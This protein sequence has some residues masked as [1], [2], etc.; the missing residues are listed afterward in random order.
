MLIVAATDDILAVHNLVSDHVD[1][2]LSL[3]MQLS[4]YL[5][6]H[7]LSFHLLVKVKSFGASEA[8]SCLLPWAEVVKTLVA[9]VSWADGRLVSIAILVHVVAW[10]VDEVGA[11]KDSAF[12]QLVVNTFI[13]IFICILIW[14]SIFVSTAYK[15]FMSAKE[16]ILAYGNFSLHLELSFGVCCSGGL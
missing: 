13:L 10:L 15:T 12:W 1:G 8:A 5:L 3:I 6:R 9:L 7:K 11:V 16:A 2:T 4:L 14:T